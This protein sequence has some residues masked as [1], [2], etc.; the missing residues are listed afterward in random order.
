MR[1]L[2]LLVVRMVMVDGVVTVARMVAGTSGKVD[3]SR[4]T[5]RVK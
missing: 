1:A 3:H 4:L 5:Y 2:E